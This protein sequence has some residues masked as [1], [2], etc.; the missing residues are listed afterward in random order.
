MIYQNQQEGLNAEISEA[1]K[2]EPARRVTTVS[3]V[4]KTG[5]TP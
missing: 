1:R 4:E 3:P 5:S 2:Q